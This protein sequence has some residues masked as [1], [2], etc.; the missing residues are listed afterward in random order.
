MIIYPTWT[1][2]IPLLVYPTRCCS[3]LYVQEVL[4]HSFYSL[5]LGHTVHHGVNVLNIICSMF[6]QRVYCKDV[7]FYGRYRSCSRK[8]SDIQRSPF[9]VRILDGCSFHYA[10]IWSK[11]EISIC[12]EHLIAPKESSNP[13]FVGKA[14]FFTSCVRNMF[15]ATILYKY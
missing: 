9:M 4:T 8:F 13:I 10:R 6:L 11:S 14:P 5:P 1:L 12:W 3:I 2:L 15:W 7:C